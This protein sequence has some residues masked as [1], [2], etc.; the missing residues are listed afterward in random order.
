MLNRLL[1][2]EKQIL[3]S[4][5]ELGIL[6]SEHAEQDDSELDEDEVEIIRGA[7][8]LSEK[9]VRDIMTPIEKL[10]W[11]TPDSRLTPDIIDQIKAKSYSR[12]PVFSPDLTVSF[13]FILMKDLVNIDFDDQII[14]VDE[15]QIY[16]S[17]PIGSMMALD[18]LFRKFISSGTH[19]IPVER[20]DRV[21]GA[22]TIEDLLE[23][24]LQHE[25]QDETDR[26]RNR[27]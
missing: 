7:L 1:G 9:H 16:P 11:L 3:L 23:E 18:T 25:I 26:S 6:I 4:R 15:L 10:Y 17:N 5:R 2:S 22:V 8:Q 19:L 14:G 13:G 21:I 24:I 20:N 12:I 27:T